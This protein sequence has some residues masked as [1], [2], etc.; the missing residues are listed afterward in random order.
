MSNSKNK[1]NWDSS[2]LEKDRECNKYITY[3]DSN[4]PHAGNQYC[5]ELK[6][7]TTTKFV[8]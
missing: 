8:F 7:D 4:G 5:Y 3:T 2:C 6:A 1:C